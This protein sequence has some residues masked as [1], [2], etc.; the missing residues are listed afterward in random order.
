VKYVTERYYQNS[1]IISIISV[2]ADLIV[3]YTLFIILF[4]IDIRKQH[5]NT[6]K[7]KKYAI[8][9]IKKLITTLGIAEIGY[10]STKFL[11]T[12]AISTFTL[13]GA[14]ISITSTIPAWIVYIYLWQI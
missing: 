14:Q 6:N 12:Y 7:N 1:L 10:L 2:A 9:D 13:L 11:S 3:F 4:Y 5:T 8:K